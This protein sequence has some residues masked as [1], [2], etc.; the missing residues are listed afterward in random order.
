MNIGVEKDM[1]DTI[2]KARRK[3]CISVIKRLRAISKSMKQ[4]EEQFL[5]LGIME[6]LLCNGGM[7]RGEES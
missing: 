7:E 4:N 1:L 5:I 3:D 6:E 2:H